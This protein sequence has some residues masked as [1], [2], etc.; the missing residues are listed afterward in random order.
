MR[1]ALLTCRCGAT[2]QPSSAIYSQPELKLLNIIRRKALRERIRPDEG[3]VIER[4]FAPLSLQST[5]SLV[6][7]IGHIRLMASWSRERETSKLV[8]KAAAKVFTE[9]PSNLRK[10]LREL[11]PAPSANIEA[12]LVEDF[13]DIYEIVRKRLENRRIRRSLRRR[14]QCPQAAKLKS[15]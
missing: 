14:Y 4:G 10:L 6:R 3:C 11:D 1:S 7:F 5:L 12:P 15:S 9:W 13:Q 2:L 8:F